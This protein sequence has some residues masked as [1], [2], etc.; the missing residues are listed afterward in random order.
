LDTAISEISRGSL[1]ARR[2]A[3]AIRRRTS[4]MLSEIDTGAISL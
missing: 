4:V 1:P 2:A 3:S